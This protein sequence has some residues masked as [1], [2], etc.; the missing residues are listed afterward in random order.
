LIVSTEITKLNILTN[1]VKV[2]SNYETLRLNENIAVAAYHGGRIYPASCRSN[3]QSQASRGG[4][5]VIDY[6][7]Y[8][9]PSEVAK[10]EKHEEKEEET[11]EVS[12]SWA[13]EV[14]REL[15]GLDNEYNENKDPNFA[16]YNNKEERKGGK[17]LTDE[18]KKA[19]VVDSNKQ[20]I[21]ENN[22]NVKINNAELVGQE[23]VQKKKRTKMDNS[24]A[25]TKENPIIT[26]TTVK[27]DQ[28]DTA[29][30]DS[31]AAIKDI[32]SKDGAAELPNATKGDMIKVIDKSKI[33]E[34][35][36]VKPHFTIVKRK[37]N[38]TKDKSS[39]DIEP[40]KKGND[41][42]DQ[43]VKDSV[44]IRTEVK[45]VTEAVQPSISTTSLQNV[46]RTE[47]RTALQVDTSYTAGVSSDSNCSQYSVGS[48]TSEQDTSSSLDPS[49]NPWG[50]YIDSGVSFGTSTGGIYSD[51][52]DISG[53]D[54]SVY[55]TT[56][57]PHS[58]FHSMYDGKSVQIYP[59]FP[60]NTK[61]CYNMDNCSSTSE[62]DGAI[63]NDDGAFQN[64]SIYNNS[65]SVP[66]VSY[67]T[68]REFSDHTS[69][70]SKEVT[71]DYCGCCACSVYDTCP[72]ERLGPGDVFYYASNSMVLCV[73][74]SKLRLLEMVKP[75]VRMVLYFSKVW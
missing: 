13:D 67:D 30:V 15:E 23:S 58:D 59:R 35:K 69:E 3:S 51:T 18:V 57:I 5:P 29:E 70:D 44:D 52:S 38:K 34:E 45:E 53:E 64:I 73:R 60:C 62:Y 17:V 27:A 68:Y 25:E 14:E 22:N 21:K 2:E 37:S 32:P 75:Q 65:L 19:D 47:M 43:T 16:I 41:K 12:E 48:W 33:V 55:E 71:C 7:D 8:V 61:L 4:A 72:Q 24:T 49:P 39:K 26:Q 56:H 50:S 74:Q 42:K 1:K 20:N 46:H 40:D 6:F 66:V 36:I 54:C 28:T 9:N 10:G 11:T 63:Q 31:L